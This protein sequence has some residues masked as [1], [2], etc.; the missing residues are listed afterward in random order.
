MTEDRG[1]NLVWRCRSWYRNW[2][3]EAGYWIKFA[4]V[5]SPAENPD[6]DRDFVKR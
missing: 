2:V 3:L 5:S 4:T 1:R 6:L